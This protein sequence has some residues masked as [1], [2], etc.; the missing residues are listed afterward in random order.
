MD[1]KDCVLT[2]HHNNIK[3][4]IFQINNAKFFVPVVSLSIKDNIKFLVIIK[5][6]F[7]G[8]ISW[9]RYR[10]FRKYKARI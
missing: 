4:A 10:I 2:E 8:T 9:N 5:Q 6:G 1:K 7:K 3:G